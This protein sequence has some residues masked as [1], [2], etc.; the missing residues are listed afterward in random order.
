MFLLSRRTSLS[1]LAGA[2]LALAACAQGKN[3]K[4]DAAFKAVGD[5]W[6]EG[7]LRLSPVFATAMGE[8]RHDAELDDL[9][10][11][12]RKAQLDFAKEILAELEALDRK[13]FSKADQ[14]DAALLEN[15]L[16]FQIWDTEVLQSWAWDPIPYNSFAGGALYGLMSREFA[17]LEARLKAASSRMAKLPAAFAQM[18]EALDPKRVPKVHAD[19]VAAQNRG[20]LSLVDGEVMTKAGALTGADREAIDKAAKDL[21]AA[22]EEHQVWLDKAL[23]PSAA[24]NFRLGQKLYD[25]KLA[26]ALFSPLS[27]AEIKTRS[28][29]GIAAT[30]KEM[31]EVAR[32]ALAGR[33]GA[34][35]APDNPDA[36]TEQKVVA[37]AF[38]IS[39]ADRPPRDKV[40]EACQRALAQA[41]AFCREKDFVTVPTR[42]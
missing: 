21:K 36:A 42:R 18:R 15:N 25:E 33:P 8:H 24:G 34:P 10:A 17:P 31:Y 19:T 32:K 26:F 41:T 13:G 12:G 28:E 38:A 14:V 9:S 7:A 11:A 16:R 20:L 30:R 29:A 5:K 35:A 3:D 22:V 27:R 6:L 40:V 1:M 37:A 39:N 4:A 2:P 23:V